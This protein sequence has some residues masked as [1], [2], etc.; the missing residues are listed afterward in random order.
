MRIDKFLADCGTGSRKDV[1]NFIKNSRVCVNG[2]TVRDSSMHVSENDKIT[3]DGEILQYM[4]YVY[5]MLNKPDGVISATYDG[6][7]TTV[8]ELVPEEFSHYDLFP[9]GRLDIDTT[10]LLIL[11][12]DGALAH[13][14]TS[15]KHH[16]DKIYSAVIDSEVDEDDADAF[17]SGITLDDGYV[18]KSADLKIVESGETS[19]IEL[20]IREGKFHQ[21]KRM[22]EARG[23]KVLK[24]K[25]IC[26]GGVYLDESLQE[27]QMRLLDE[28]EI[29]I[30]TSN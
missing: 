21:V 7:H 5:L 17:C 6:R 9:V 3:L 24:L 2:K 23:K 12:N 4:K 1:K 29:E 28:K 14:L 16:A 13:R 20:T 8:I 25:R 30:L 15:P 11:T 18:C 22:F 27:G 19:K 26:M 10:G